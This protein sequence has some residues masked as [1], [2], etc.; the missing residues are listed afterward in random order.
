MPHI[1]LTEDGSNTLY[2]DHFKVT[3][4]SKYGA[5]Q[6]AETVFINAALRPVLARQTSINILEIGLGTGLNALMT[7]L[8]LAEYPETTAYYTAL[9]AYPVPL[10]IAASLNFASCFPLAKNAEAFLHTIHTSEWQQSCEIA[11]NHLFQKKLQDFQTIDIENEYDIIYYDAFAP[12]SQPELWTKEIFEQMYA[13]LRQNGILTT[14]C[15]KG[16]VKRNLRAAGFVIEN[17][18]GP[19]GKREMTRAIK[20]LT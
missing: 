14:Y 3:Y 4:H 8:T 6:E 15:A 2:S 9:E 7:F 12:N 5:I 17:L 11:E 18:P 19:I 1:L 13:A 10:E 16:Q 20:S